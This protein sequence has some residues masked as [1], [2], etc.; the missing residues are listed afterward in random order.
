[1]S[2]DG[3]Q[4]VSEHAGALYAAKIAIKAAAAKK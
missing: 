2:A 3:S 4:V 1:V